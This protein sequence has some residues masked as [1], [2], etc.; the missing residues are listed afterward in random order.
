MIQ[1]CSRIPASW[2]ENISFVLSAGESYS[3][4]LLAFR[5]RACSSN[6]VSFWIFPLKERNIPNISAIEEPF[7]LTRWFSSSLCPRHI[8]W[9]FYYCLRRSL[10]SVR[11]STN[12]LSSKAM[13]RNLQNLTRSL[14]IPMV[15]QC[16]KSL[17]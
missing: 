5:C 13:W 9:K 14:S 1:H 8:V 10:Y 17:H 11:S 2:V 7:A 16:S 3:C 15:L 6:S 12:S 4:P